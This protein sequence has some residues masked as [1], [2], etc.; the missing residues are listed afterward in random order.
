MAQTYPPKPVRVIVPFSPGGPADFQ[1]R[2][3]A[4]KLSEAWGQQLIVDNRGGANGIIAVE[5]GAKADPHGYTLILTPAGFPINPTLYPKVPYDSRRD[6]A[7]VPQLTSGP[8]IL[9]LHPSLPARSV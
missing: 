6:F 1:V 8:G 4:P 3:M 7:G 5:L 9:F 2:L